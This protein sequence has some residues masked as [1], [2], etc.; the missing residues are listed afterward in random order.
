MSKDNLEYSIEALRIKALFYG[1]KAMIYVE[2][3]D[4]EIFWEQ[5]FD[6]EAFEIESVKGASNLYGYIDRLENGEKSYIVACDSDYTIYKKVKYSSPLVVTTYGH[7]IE[8]MMYC[9]YN[10]NEAVKKIAKSRKDTI[11]LINS[12][13]T[14]FVDKV[15]PLLLREITNQ[16]YQA[17]DT[18][19][20]V[21]GDTS[22]KYSEKRKSSE[23]DEN[24]IKSFCK[25]N[26]LY[27][28]EEELT[29]VEEYVNQDQREERQL[30]K[31]H[32]L[33]DAVRYLVSSLAS[34]VSINTKKYN[35]SKD[36]LYTLTIKCECRKEKSC[37]EK[38][39]IREHVRKAID[40]V[41]I[42]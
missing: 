23:L 29:K 20:S 10:L 7:S 11:E 14:N 28:P 13:Y 32:F 8:N 5:Y 31:G 40:Y 9:P 19:I 1:K 38:S 18:K 35:V 6:T 16:V 26:A 42:A 27:F 12:W 39:Y 30:I 25:R 22:S 3:Q 17:K 4:D 37:K 36:W 33:T 24:L 21:F 41:E 34:S 15:H 2:G